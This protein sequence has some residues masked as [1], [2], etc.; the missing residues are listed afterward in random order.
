MV[1]HPSDARHHWI[2]GSAHLGFKIMTRPSVEALPDPMRAAAVRVARVLAAAGKRGWIVGGAVRDLAL[3]RVP[4]DLDMA[5][6]ALPAEVEALFV[7]SV[8]VGKAFGTI[9]LPQADGA[10]VQLTSFRSEGGYSDARRPD[11]VSFGASVEE[12]ASRRDFTCNALFLDPLTDALC[13][14]EGGLA[15]LAAGRLACVGEACERFRE[16]ALRLLRL[17]RFAASLGLAVDEATRAAARA[18]AA[19][20]ARISRERVRAELAALFRGAGIDQALG[21]LVELELWEPALGRGAPDAIELA[22]RCAA[23]QRLG[24]EPGELL[25]LALLLGPIPGDG[26][27]PAYCTEQL[28]RLRPSRPL[29]RAVESLWEGLEELGHLVDQGV[30]IAERAARRRLQARGDWECLLRLARAWGADRPVLEQ[31]A[32]SLQAEASELTD[33]EL[34]PAPLLGAEDLAD[35]GLPRGR[36]WGVL[37]RALEDQQLAGALTTRAEA[38]TWLQREV[39]SGSGGREDPT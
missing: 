25:G 9:V 32:M 27:V 16:D 35:S 7:E 11:E 38:L 1:A 23:M 6:A 13:D 33:E 22:Q 39:A 29:Q 15:D 2:L 34:H 36:A 24:A 10:P 21:A 4:G 20:L 37:L 28:L 12:D 8:S 17:V 26:A 5:S 31:R 3:G 30:E 19:G 14:P 18:E